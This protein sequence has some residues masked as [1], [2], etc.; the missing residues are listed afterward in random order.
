MATK[1]AVMMLVENKQLAPPL[2]DPW[3]RQGDQVLLFA[4]SG[5]G[6]SWVALKIA[7]SLCSG[8]KCLNWQPEK[9]IKCVYFDGEMGEQHLNSVFEKIDNGS[10]KQIKGG[11]LRF[12]CPGEEN[13]YQLPDLSHPEG[14]KWYDS[15]SEGADLIVIDN[16]LTCCRLQN[17][18]DSD[19]NQWARVQPW[20]IKKRSEGV[21][22]LV[23]HHAGK[24]GDQLGTSSREVMMNCVVRL[25]PLRALNFDIEEGSKFEWHWKKKRGFAG[26]HAQPMVVSHFTNGCNAQKWSSQSLI[27]WKKEQYKNLRCNHSKIS[28]QTMMGINSAEATYLETFVTQDDDDDFTF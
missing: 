3:L 16:L 11:Y 21:T 4:E 22:V 28:A 20:L 5:L 26:E 14:Q 1:D 6:K 19:F 2:F 10:E 24:S 23:I 7:H 12:A 9:Q 27:E 18:R 8:S 17:A 13:N 25:S 15:E